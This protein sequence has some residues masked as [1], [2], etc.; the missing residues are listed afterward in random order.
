MNHE[1]YLYHV[2]PLGYCPTGYEE[3]LRDLKQGGDKAL[4]LFSKNDLGGMQVSYLLLNWKQR[5]Q[6]W[7]CFIIPRK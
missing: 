7:E 2:K 1:M 3:S 5:D 6:F 4:I